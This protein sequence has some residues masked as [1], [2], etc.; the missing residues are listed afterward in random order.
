MSL[1]PPSN[2]LSFFNRVDAKALNQTITGAY[3]CGPYLTNGPRNWF[4][5]FVGSKIA[6]HLQ[7]AADS[8][9]L[10]PIVFPAPLEGFE[11]NFASGEHYLARMGKFEMNQGATLHEILHLVYIHHRRF[12]LSSTHRGTRDFCLK[13]LATLKSAFF[14]KDMD[15]DQ[16]RSGLVG[17]FGEIHPI[18][19][20]LTL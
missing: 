16:V 9:E 10:K 20:L 3:I 5:V 12:C 1:T 6:W 19:P 11:A 8:S 17:A 2:L 14:F 13:I 7:L 4:L 15:V 18:F